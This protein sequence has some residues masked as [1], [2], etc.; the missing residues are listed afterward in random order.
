MKN[1]K[2]CAICGKKYEYCNNCSKYANLPRWMFLFHNE[3]CKRIY[4]VV[5]DYKTNA[6]SAD[7]AKAKLSKLNLDISIV[8]AIK[9]TVDEIMRTGKI[10]APKSEKKEFNGFK[11]NK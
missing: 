5:N 10:E 4:D 9:K 6:I 2:T 11:K 7:S 1:E 3:N 8:P